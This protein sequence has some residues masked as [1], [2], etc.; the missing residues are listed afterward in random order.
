MAA[1]HAYAAT[2]ASVVWTNQDSV[3]HTVTSDT[4]AWDSGNLAT[5]Q[6]FSHTFATAGTYSYHCSIHPFM[7]ARV[8]VSRSGMT[9]G[10]AALTVLHVT[11]RP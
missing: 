10:H 1:L 11:L 7:T 6:T 9:P 3:A 8:I 2:A 5:G 4:A